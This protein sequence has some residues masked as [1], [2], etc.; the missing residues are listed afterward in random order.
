MEKVIGITGMGCEGCAAK[1][2]KA[3]EAVPGVKSVKVELAAKRAVV[4]AEGVADQV[5]LDAV[6]A[7][8]KYRAESIE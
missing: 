8:G 5:L 7:I 4:E 2:R 3:L 1:V 6:N